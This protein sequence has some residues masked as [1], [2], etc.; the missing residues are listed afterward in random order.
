MVNNLINHDCDFFVE[1]AGMQM[2]SYHVTPTIEL[3]APLPQQQIYASSGCF[4]RALAGY[5]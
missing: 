2:L 5:I 1:K 3:R 4:Q